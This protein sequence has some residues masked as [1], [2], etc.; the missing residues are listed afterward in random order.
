[1]VR[2][3]FDFFYKETSTLHKA[4]Y[5][6]GFFAV[7]SQVLAFLRD[8]LLAHVFGAGAALDT[9]YAAFRIPDFLFVTVASVVSI[10]VIVPFIIEKEKLGN[11]AVR[12]FVDNLFTFFSFLI[13]GT[14]GAA[15]FLIPTFSGILF[16]GFSERNSQM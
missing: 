2:R 13:I 6:L 14:C 5:L 15:F 9:Y 12:E 16:K 10:S 8:R 4:A 3:I 11:E 7:L 1:M